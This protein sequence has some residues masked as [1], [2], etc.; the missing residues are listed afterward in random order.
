MFATASRNSSERASRRCPGA[1]S[2]VCPEATLSDTTGPR[3]TAAAV[4]RLN[5]AVTHLPCAGSG[6]GTGRGGTARTVPPVHRL[7]Y[8][9]TVTGPDVR[10]PGVVPRR[11]PV[12]DRGR[13]AG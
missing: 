3:P 6:Q 9:P 2:K 10:P 7:V 1:P 8:A 13:H 11:E 12:P 4:A 5:F